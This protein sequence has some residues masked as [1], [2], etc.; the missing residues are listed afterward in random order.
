MELRFYRNTYHSYLNK[1]IILNNKIIRILQNESYR[2]HVAEFFMKTI[3]PFQF[4]NSIIEF[5]HWFIN[6]LTIT[7][8]Y[9]SYFQHI[10]MIINYFMN[11]ILV[12][13]IASPNWL[14]YI[15]W[16]QMYKI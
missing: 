6:V 8:N 10:L 7:A 4:Q 5:C 12:G 13:K 15:Y 2:T 9:L 16:T 3:T 1:L 11:I 14:P